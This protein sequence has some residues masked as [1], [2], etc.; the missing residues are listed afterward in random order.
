MIYG[1]AEIMAVNKIKNA[2]SA[3]S[4]VVKGKAI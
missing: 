2:N 3:Y 1:N 4:I